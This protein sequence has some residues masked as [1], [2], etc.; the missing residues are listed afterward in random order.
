MTGQSNFW[1]LCPKLSTALER[2]C[3]FT[4]PFGLK[5]RITRS[6]E[7]SWRLMNFFPACCELWLSAVE[8]LREKLCRQKKEDKENGRHEFIL[9]STLKQSSGGGARG[10]NLHSNREVT[11]WFVLV[12]WGATLLA[13][14]CSF[15]LKYASFV[16]TVRASAFMSDGCSERWVTWQNHQLPYEHQGSIRREHIGHLFS[17]PMSVDILIH[18]EERSQPLDD[19]NCCLAFLPSQ[20]PSIF[21]SPPPFLNLQLSMPQVCFFCSH[22]VMLSV[23]IMY[24]KIQG[25]KEKT[26]TSHKPQWKQIDR[27]NTSNQANLSEQA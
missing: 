3:C 19:V 17:E 18:V 8:N 24:K 9:S 25:R 5:A 23:G 14:N 7:G 12:D 27:F 13:C 15:S 11:K 22:A 4:R 6:S 26:D 20:R 16:T 21:N 2:A 10:S 1:E